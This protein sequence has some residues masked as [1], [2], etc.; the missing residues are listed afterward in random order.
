MLDFK[1]MSDLVFC[2]QENYGQKE[3]EKVARVK[4]LYEALG[5][6]A[7]YQEYE[8]SSFQHLQQLIEVHTPHLPKEIFLDLAHVIYKRQK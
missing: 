7:V 6:R 4:E 5:L 3:L 8:D 2:F 1:L